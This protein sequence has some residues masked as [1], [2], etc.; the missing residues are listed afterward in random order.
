MRPA[1]D[2]LEDVLVAV[3][4]RAPAIPVVNN[5]DVAHPDDPASIRDALVRQLYKPV[6]WTET[7]HALAAG[8]VHRIVECGPGKVLCGLQ[9][10]IDRGVDTN[11][12]ETP[13][14]LDAALSA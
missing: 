3:E 8:G 7:M 13:D 10:R 11:F 5:V 14:G 4:V 1:A 2:Q 9:R 12:L 6:R